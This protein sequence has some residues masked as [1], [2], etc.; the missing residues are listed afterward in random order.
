LPKNFFAHNIFLHSINFNKISIHFFF[1]D[2]YIS[3]TDMWLLNRELIHRCVTEQANITLN[4]LGTQQSNCVIQLNHIY[5]ENGNRLKKGAIITP[6]TRF[7]F[8]SSSALF[9]IFI[10]GTVLITSFRN[11]FIL[12]EFQ[13]SFLTWFSCINVCVKAK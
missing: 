10:Q 6:K 5:H 11:C 4:S 1:Q 2:Y 8:R 13:N 12:S 3:R 7:A 9:Y